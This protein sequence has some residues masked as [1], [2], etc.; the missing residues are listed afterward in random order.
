MQALAAEGRLQVSGRTLRQ[1]VYFGEVPPREA[2]LEWDDL[3]L[4]PP[5]SEINHPGGER[6][7]G[8]KPLGFMHRLIAMSSEDHEVV[9]DP[10]CGSGTTLVAAHRLGRRWIG[11]DASPEAIALTMQRL[12]Q[13]TGLEATDWDLRRDTLM[14]YPSIAVT[15][16]PVLAHVGQVEELR[17]QIEG[18]ARSL[19]RIRSAA[20]LEGEDSDS[21]V[22]KL[23]QRIESFF[24]EARPKT[25]EAYVEKVRA[26]LVEWDRLEEASQRFLPQAEFLMDVLPATDESDFSPFIIQY[27]RALENEILQKLFIAYSKDLTS[28]VQDKRSFLA[29]DLDNKKTERFANGLLGGIE[30][31]ALGDMLW[32]M[33]LI[34]LPG[35]RNLERSRVLKDFRDFTERYFG[36]RLRDAEFL[37]QIDLIKTDYRNK[38]AHPYLL[39]LRVAIK[40]REAVRNCLSEFLRNYRSG[41]KEGE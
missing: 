5:P 27:C 28:R 21:V 23:E 19:D 14:M 25:L 11:A 24:S 39:D 6:F 32:T 9:L 41:A 22:E 17:Q 33:R 29:D 26:W 40:C 10:F 4:A 30:T 34:K 31:F 1:K 37:D 8:Q 36:K 7:P 15:P 20:G 12:A 38:A 35:G 13:E 18:L 2:P 16:S 3:P